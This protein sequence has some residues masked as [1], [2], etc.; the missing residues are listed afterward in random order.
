MIKN[1]NIIFFLFVAASMLLTPIFYYSWNGLK[2]TDLEGIDFSGVNAAIDKCIVNDN[3]FTVSGWAY[4][5]ETKSTKYDGITYIVV[6]SGEDYY[7]ARTKRI[8]RKD[9]SSHFKLGNNADNSGFISGYSFAISGVKPEKDF[10]VVTEYNGIKR[11]VKRAC[12]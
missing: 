4:P 5:E 8:I 11:G 3:S 12:K 2:K 1:R 6:K 7:K 10:Y 9:V